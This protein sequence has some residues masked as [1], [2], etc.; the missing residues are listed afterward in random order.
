GRELTEAR[1]RLAGSNQY[2][3]VFIRWVE[4]IG[5]THESVRRLINR[6]EMLSTK[7]GEQR[8]LIEDLPVTLSYSISAPSSESTPEKAQA[9][10]EVLAGDITTNK[11]YHDRI[12]ELE[13]KAESAEL[14]AEQAEERAEDAERVAVI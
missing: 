10:E 12:K 1:D 4:S 7:C 6:Y 11:A 13:E 5:M 2:D 3:G 9:K 8:N 14:R